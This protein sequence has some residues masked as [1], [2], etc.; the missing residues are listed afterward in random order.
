[1]KLPAEP[2]SRLAVLGVGILVGLVLFGLG[3]WLAEQ[4]MTWAT[5]EL[6]EA[7]D[8]LSPYS[9]GGEGSV[10]AE[11][12]LWLLAALYAAP[13]V[14]LCASGSLPRLV[15]ES[16]RRLRGVTVIP[17]VALVIVGVSATLGVIGLAFDPSRGGHESITSR[18][19][20]LT[21]GPAHLVVAGAWVM[22][23]MLILTLATRRVASRPMRI[24]VR[25]AG[26]IA[27]TASLGALFA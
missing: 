15:D 22:V 27:L 4:A 7:L 25:A 20:E 6:L 12:A 17:D 24:A 13:G 26:F 11:P 3:M 9:Y 10:V 8:M 14:L 19:P 16:D 23:A 21:S 5:L 1:M 18:V 2:R